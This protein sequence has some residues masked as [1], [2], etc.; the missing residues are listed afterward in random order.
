M[1]GRLALNTMFQMTE[2]EAIEIATAYVAAAG[3]EELR[4]VGTKGER[5][6]RRKSAQDAPEWHVYFERLFSESRAPMDPSMVIVIV[7]E[8]TRVARFLPTL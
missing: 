7:D 4:L 3:G 6:R 5:K 8:N 2:A 1:D